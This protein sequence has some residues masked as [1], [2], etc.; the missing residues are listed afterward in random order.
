VIGLQG[1]EPGRVTSTCVETLL[2]AGG[3][4]AHVLTHML[5]FALLAERRQVLKSLHHPE[6]SSPRSA[7]VSDGQHGC[8]TRSGARNEAPVSGQPHSR[9]KGALLGRQAYRPSFVGQRA[10]VSGSRRSEA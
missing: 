9:R 3:S 1:P 5:S 8:S 2:C 7:V 4:A 6:A 10:G